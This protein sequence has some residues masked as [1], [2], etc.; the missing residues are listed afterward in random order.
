MAHDDSLYLT[1]ILESIQKIEAYSKLRSDRNFMNSTIVQDA[2]IRQLAVI[3]EAANRLSKPFI[4]SNPQINWAN[5]VGMRNKLIHDY[6]GLDSD[7]IWTTVDNDIP[8]L[9]SEIS[10]L[11]NNN[12]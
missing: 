10:K 3:G 5:I 8:Y 11:L 1:H 2:V 9:K 12:K 7:I 6:F 4:Q